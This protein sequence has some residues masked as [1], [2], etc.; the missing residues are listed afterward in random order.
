MNTCT[1]T[2]THAHT[3]T[4][5][6]TKDWPP[7][8]PYPTDC[9]HLSWKAVPHKT[10]CHLHAQFGIESQQ[11][12]FHP[13]SPSSSATRMLHWGTRWGCLAQDCSQMWGSHLHGIWTAHEICDVHFLFFALSPLTVGYHGC[14][15][16]FFFF[17]WESMLSKVTC[18]TLGVGQNLPGMLCMLP[19]ILPL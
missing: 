13:S 7:S 4:H 15:N 11:S 17:C 2:H 8:S 14:R 9:P 12:G 6:H 16:S 10:G 5:I 18:F 1:H 3:H 19:Q